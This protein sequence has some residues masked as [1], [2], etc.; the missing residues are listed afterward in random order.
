M[1]KKSS[2]FWYFVSFPALIGLLAVLLY[3]LNWAEDPT[4]IPSVL[5]QTPATDFELESL[6][7]QIFTVQQWQGQPVVLNFW[8]SWCFACRAE[9]HI[10]EQAHQNFS[11]RGAQIVGIAVHDNAPDVRQ[12]IQQYGKSY[13]ILLDVS[14]QTMLEY[15]VTGIPETFFIDTA[16][17]ITKKITG[18][19]T[20]AQ[21]EGFV[22][23]Q[24]ALGA[25]DDE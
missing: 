18:A 7:N 14:G 1:F 9:A 21:I 10:L 12:F 6:D 3:G 22:N 20:Y 16:G 13:L 24:L 5:E 25:T 17:M 15:G 23:A 19:V 11:P 2:Y 4:K 8:G